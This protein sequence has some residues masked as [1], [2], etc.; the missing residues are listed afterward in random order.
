[1][2]DWREMPCEYPRQKPL[3]SGYVPISVRGKPVRAHRLA[4]EE[5]FG[6]IPD[7]LW[8]L[9]YCDHPS[10]WQPLHLWLGTA[11]D[12]IDDMRRK[13]RARYVAPYHP[14]SNRN[15][16]VGERNGMAKLVVAQVI[17]IRQR[18]AAG[19]E[20]RALAVVYGVTPQMIR[21][22]GLRLNWKEI[23]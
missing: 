22:I 5:C 19:E 6:P 13:G 7:G 16:Q 1:M 21:R 10:C 18:L 3:A 17:E 9:H 15:P 20:Y 14:A 11:Q 12:N 8:V 2:A 4:W 23:P